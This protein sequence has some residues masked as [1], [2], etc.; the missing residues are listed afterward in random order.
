MRK[1]ACPTALLA[2]LSLA[3]GCT[4]YFGD[5]DDDDCALYDEAYDSEPRDPSTGECQYF[6]GGGGG[7]GLENDGA[8][9]PAPDWASCYTQCEGLDEQTCIAT[10]ACRAAYLE[11]IGCGPGTDCLPPEPGSNT[12]YGCWG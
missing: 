11:D 6:G 4:L 8:E 5:D 12:F 3:S 1:L 2:L 9:A 7:C 10:A